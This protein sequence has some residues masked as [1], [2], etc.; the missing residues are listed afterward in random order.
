M[1][2]WPAIEGDRV[3]LAYGYSIDAKYTVSICRAS[4]NV[5]WPDEMELETTAKSQPLI[6]FA[7]AAVLNGSCPPKPQFLVP[8]QSVLNYLMATIYN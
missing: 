7:H 5:L 4:K 3:V 1:E 2:L 8:W 6:A